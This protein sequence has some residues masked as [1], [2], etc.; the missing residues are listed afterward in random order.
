MGKKYPALGENSKNGVR[1]IECDSWRKFE[2][3]IE[4]FKRPKYK[5]VWRG[6]SCEKRL[7]PSIYRDSTPNDKT[8]RQHLY[9]FRKE[10]PGGDAL[11]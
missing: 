9:R 8:I 3:K 6:Q 10:M 7:K 5:Y 11:Q 1:N 4:E 2:D